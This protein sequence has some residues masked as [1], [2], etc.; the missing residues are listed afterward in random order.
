MRLTLRELRRRPG[1]FLPVGLAMTLL[2]V[3][4]VVLGGF[5]DGLELNQTGAFR[6]QGERLWVID[7]GAELQ[8]G[9]SLLD[10]DV[11]ETVAGV[12]GVAEIGGIASFVTT[13][14]V[15]DSGEVVDLAVFGYETGTE[16]PPDPP[17]AGEAVLDAQLSR[18]TTGEVGDELRIGPG[19]EPV[20]IT[21]I[22]DDVSQGAVTA[23]L[24]LDAWRELQRSAAPQAALPP[25]TVQAL[26]VTPAEGTD[27]VTLAAL[28]DEAT[29]S[30][31]TVDLAG[32]VDGQPVVAQQSATFQ[33]IIGITFVV[34]L[35]VVALFFALLILERA[36]L[37]AVL[38]AIGGRSRDLVAGVIVQALVIAVAALVVG[39][40]ASV[41]IV[42]ALPADLPV[43]LEPQ[44][45]ATIAVATLLTSV[46]GV[47]LVLRRILR[48]DPARAIG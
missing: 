31:T 18:L 33:G 32:L 38:K 20:T 28:I 21:A 48:I 9:R 10:E 37:Y 17:G 14:T 27:P 44:R 23:W 26:V 1:R 2:V 45:L 39:G 4:L 11:A 35:L 6:A 34:V 5:L 8:L 30:T 13:G 36:R 40:L 7:D 15:P 41:A 19:N 42:A 43:R 46:L 47:A 29:G 12:D 25:G 3:L 24:D 22:A 16:V